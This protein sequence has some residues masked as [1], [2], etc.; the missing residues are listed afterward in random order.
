VLQQ[1]PPFLEAYDVSYCMVVTLGG[2]RVMMMQMMMMLMV[3]ICWESG[4]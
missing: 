1:N 4:T 2:S 3:I